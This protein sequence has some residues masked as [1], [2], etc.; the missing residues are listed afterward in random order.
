MIVG[1]LL[2]ILGLLAII[3]GP[4]CTC[5]KAVDNFKRVENTNQEYKCSQC[6]WLW[7]KC[8]AFGQDIQ[9]SR[10][11]VIIA[12]NA[13][14]DSSGNDPI[15]LPQTNDLPKKYKYNTISPIQ[16][17][18]AAVGGVGILVMLLTPIVAFRMGKHYLL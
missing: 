10:G 14:G 11:C 4:A 15:C 8:S 3:T 13:N 16:I 18:G 17:I 5:S 12:V 1:I 2:A 9:C 6:S 7:L